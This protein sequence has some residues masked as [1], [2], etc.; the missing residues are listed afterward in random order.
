MMGL[1]PWLEVRILPRQETP[2]TLA[3]QTRCRSAKTHLP[4]AD[5][6][7]RCCTL[8]EDAA[9]AGEKSDDDGVGHSRR[10]HAAGWWTVRPP[11]LQNSSNGGDPC[12]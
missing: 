1:S 12:E 3:Q 8:F 11:D 6:I 2:Q 9:P 7:A 10:A 5:H 4:G